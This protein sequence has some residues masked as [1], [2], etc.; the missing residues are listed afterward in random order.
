[1]P[2]EVAQALLRGVP[3]QRLSESYESASVAFIALADFDA[4]MA[5]LAPKEQ[6]QVRLCRRAS[7]A[8][9]G[10]EAHHDTLC[11]G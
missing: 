9:H 6:L 2:S 10:F 1:M 11:S 4:R 3:M 8:A 5:R 7:T